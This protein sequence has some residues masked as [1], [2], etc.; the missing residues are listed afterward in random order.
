M[1]K[2]TLQKK[3]LENDMNAATA[4]TEARHYVREMVAK[5]TRG[6]GDTLP[7]LERLCARHKLSFWTLNNLRIGRAKTAEGGLLRRI[8]GAYLRECER[9]LLNVKHEL[10]GGLHG[11]APHQDLMAEIQTLVAKVKAAKEHAKG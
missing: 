7:A 9:Q 6:W 5:E 1:C 3:H 11:D 2:E 8:K 4:A 10:E